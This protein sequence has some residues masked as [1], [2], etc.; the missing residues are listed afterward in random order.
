M[1]DAD[2]TYD[3][4]YCVACYWHLA[5]SVFLGEEG[6]SKVV[7][8][9][10]LKTLEGEVRD[11]G[12]DETRQPIVEH[13]LIEALKRSEWLRLSTHKV[14]SLPSMIKLNDTTINFKCAN[15]NKIE[16]LIMTVFVTNT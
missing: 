6:S 4:Y 12:Y 7:A 16:T 11:G 8:R 13:L 2:E 14:V 10:R 1:G 5:F 3:H 15:L 9:G